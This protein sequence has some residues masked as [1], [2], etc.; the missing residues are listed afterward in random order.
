MKKLLILCSVLL[1]SF[2]AG[3]C[4]AKRTEKPEIIDAQELARLD[5]I[6]SQELVRRDSIS[7]FRGLYRVLQVKDNERALFRYSLLLQRPDTV[8][9]DIFPSTGAYTL[10][11]FL[12]RGG[13][14]LALDPGNLRAMRSENSSRVIRALLGLP[15]SADELASVALGTFPISLARE[16][17]E[18]KRSSK[19]IVASAQEGKFLWRFSPDGKQIDSVEVRRTAKGTMRANVKY[20]RY[21]V[22]AG[23]NVPEVI[24]IEIP[25]ENLRLDLTLVN[26]SVNKEISQEKFV[27][28]VPP[29]YT[30]WQG[31]SGE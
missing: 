30:L 18:V 5:K 14:A 7:S 10:G 11:L 3:G 29:E 1:A 31:V 23:A 26:G 2:F 16:S 22:E 25:E 4:A 17:F 27:I 8:R 21:R 6:I 20:Q 19:S 15:L 24:S 9:L 28:D 12:S 13:H